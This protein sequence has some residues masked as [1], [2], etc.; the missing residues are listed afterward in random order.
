MVITNEVASTFYSRPVNSSGGATVQTSISLYRGD[1]LSLRCATDKSSISS[2]NE[3]VQP[4]ISGS[5]GVKL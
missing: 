5:T 2:I 1:G 4:D 3:Y